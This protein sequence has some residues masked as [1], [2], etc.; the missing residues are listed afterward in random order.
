MAFINNEEPRHYNITTVAQS[1]RFALY[2]IHRFWSFITKDET[3]LLVQALV[4]SR[5]DYCNSLLAGLP[6]SATKP[7]RRI[8][9]A[10]VRLIHNLPKFSHVTPPSFVTSTG[11]LLQHPIPDNGAGLQGHQRNCTHLPPY[12]GQTTH[13]SESTLLFYISW[14]VVTPSLRANKPTQRRNSSLFWHLSGRTN[15][16]PTSGQRNHTPSST[17]DSRLICS[18]FT[19]SPHSM[20]PS[21]PPYQN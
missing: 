9:N 13:P 20:T 7:L 10:A 21:Q 5:L 17:K 15:S 11:F 6:A 4:I 2:N 1:C 14:P 3:Q 16:Q 19:S 18:D 8:Q 12:T